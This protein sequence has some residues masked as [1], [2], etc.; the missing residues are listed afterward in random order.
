MNPPQ[1]SRYPL[2][3]IRKLELEELDTRKDMV[4]VF[5]CSHERDSRRRVGRLSVK[6]K[7]NDEREKKSWEMK[8]VVGI[9]VAR[10]DGALSV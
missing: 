9:Y 5:I 10:E 6:G 8:N 3:V 1:T 4:L 7:R 2:A